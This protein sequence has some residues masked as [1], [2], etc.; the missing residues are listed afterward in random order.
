M[1]VGTHDYFSAVA[2]VNGKWREL[3]F[4]EYNNG[5]NTY[6]G[7]IGWNLRYT[8]GVFAAELTDVDNPGYSFVDAPT[9]GL[10]YT[11]LSQLLTLS[12][13][14]DL[15]VS[16]VA[17]NTVTKTLTLSAIN[18]G[19]GTGEVSITADGLVAVQSIGSVL[20]FISSNVTRMTSDTYGFDIN[21]A[22]SNLDV[23]VGGSITLDS[24][25]DSRFKITANSAFN[26]TLEIYSINSGTGVG[27]LALLCDGDLSNTVSANSPG[28]QTLGLLA[29]NIGAG[30]AQVTIS[31]QNSVQLDSTVGNISLDSVTSS[32][33][34]VTGNS[35]GDQ[36]LTIRATNGG[37]G[38]GLIAITADNQITITSTSGRV[39]IM[40]N[41]AV[42]AASLDYIRNYFGGS[43]ISGGASSAAYGQVFEGTI[44]TVAGDT[45]LCGS[46]F[47]NFCTTSNTTETL[48]VVAQ[49]RIDEP[50]ITK[51]ATDTIT[52]A[53]T[54]YISGTPTEATNNYAI[55]AAGRIACSSEITAATLIVTNL[56]DNYLPYHVSDA[57]GLANSGY[58]WV[59]SRAVIST[60]L[61][62]GTATAAGNVKNYFIGAFTSDGAQDRVYAQY[63]GGGLTGANGDTYGIIGTRFANSLITQNN[64]ETLGI[65][66]QVYIDEPTIIKGTDTITIASSL[67]VA[68]APTEGVNNYALCIA[69]GTTR[70]AE[71]RASYDATTYT[72]LNWTSSWGFEMSYAANTATPSTFTINSSNTGGGAASLLINGSHAIALGSTSGSVSAQAKTS[73]S[74]RIIADSAIDQTLTLSC[75]NAGVGAGNVAITAEDT[76]N[77]SGL[78]ESLLFND[79]G[80]TVLD[81]LYYSAS[82]IIGALNEVSQ[83]SGYY[84]ENTMSGSSTDTV[85]DTITDVN[86]GSGIYKGGIL[87]YLFTIRGGTTGISNQVA[88]GTIRI[89]FHGSSAA[90][91]KIDETWVDTPNEDITFHADI[92]GDDLILYGDNASASANDFSAHRRKNIA[93]IEYMIS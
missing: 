88:G 17:N 60:N 11:L 77:F 31:G 93:S 80:N 92:V 14:N 90:T 44:T 12:S 20:E 68:N 23:D 16:V 52:T 51:G 13:E 54:L 55:Y 22:S 3:D 78:G 5:Q 37:A 49:V 25:N 19:S 73:S 66:A 85:L 33:F 4:N 42:G 62:V 53:C 34:T 64:T 35:V 39:Q 76:I 15:T 58:S 74:Y 1:T 56:T 47:N 21:S 26:R 45:I 61:T 7:I 83:G 2:K 75:T 65:V 32:N 79:T 27:H 67:Y 50:N 43:F 69:S 84:I 70:T 24:A 29:T 91:I 9:S 8:K 38:A 48:G 59:S 72:S 63:F 36:T 41:I 40:P 87:E 28:T 46:R 86:E 10:S 89:K 6:N 71:L 57:A 82:S 18:S 81:P 30:T